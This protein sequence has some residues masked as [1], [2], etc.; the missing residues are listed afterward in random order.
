M[1][2]YERRL[3]W[4]AIPLAV[5]ISFPLTLAAIVAGYGLA[6]GQTL[7]IGILGM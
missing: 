5:A 7:H 4:V 1:N 3:L 2:P 6:T